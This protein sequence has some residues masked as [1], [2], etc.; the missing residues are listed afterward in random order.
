MRL[1]FEAASAIQ[2][3]VLALG[4]IET[5]E[6]VMEY[7]SVGAT[8]VQVGTAHFADPRASCE[9]VDELKKLCKSANISN[10]NEI[11]WKFQ[12]DSTC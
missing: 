12:S 9:I 8:A 10:I 5:G 3:P 6:D 4:G 11:R 2:R 1:V 7:L